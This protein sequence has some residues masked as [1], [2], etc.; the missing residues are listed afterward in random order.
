MIDEKSLLIKSIKVPRVLKLA[1][2]SLFLY[3]PHI[4]KFPNYH[5]NGNNFLP[6]EKKKF[7]LGKNF[8]STMNLHSTPFHPWLN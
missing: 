2:I 8:L 6:Y 1:E 7:A 4:I 5:V 3:D